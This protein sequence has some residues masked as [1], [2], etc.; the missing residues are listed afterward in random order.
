MSECSASTPGPRSSTPA[1]RPSLALGS[2]EARPGWIND[3]LAV[4][5]VFQ[6]ALSFDHRVVDGQLGSMFLA[7]VGAL[8]AD[9]G[10]AMVF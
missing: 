8:L 1:S 3:E 6:L 7:D 5:K 9:P 4:R 2:I 10:M